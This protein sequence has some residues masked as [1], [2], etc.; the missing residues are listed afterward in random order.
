VDCIKRIKEY[1]DS[2]ELDDFLEN[3]MTIDAVV[4]N[5]EIIGEATKH[6]P[7]KIKEKYPSIP[8]IRVQNMRNVVVH[9]YWG[10]DTDVLWDIIQ[11]K[12]DE[13]EEQIQD[14]LSKENSHA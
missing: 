11:H 12:L 2:Q 10:V 6:V 7:E 8:W 3:R 5:I 14:V 13:L 4:R 1:T 9:K